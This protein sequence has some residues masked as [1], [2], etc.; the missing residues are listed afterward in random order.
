MLLLLRL[1]RLRRLLLLL[2]PDVA[3]WRCSVHETV[4][5]IEVGNPGDFKDNIDMIK[6]HFTYWIILKS[7][8][9]LSTLLDEL[10]K[11]RKTPS[12]PR[13]W[14]NFR[15]FLAVFRQECM[16]QLASFGPT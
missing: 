6:V 15:P 11:V 1:L 10:P 12:W 4:D 13:S 3:D 8:L 7:N 16:D 2:L 14:A 9:L 5:M